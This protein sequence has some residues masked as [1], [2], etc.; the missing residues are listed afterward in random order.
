MELPE[1]FIDTRI[2]E[3]A[4]LRGDYET[5]IPKARFSVHFILNVLLTIK[6]V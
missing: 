5:N 6:I 4:A 3:D 2:V 1:S